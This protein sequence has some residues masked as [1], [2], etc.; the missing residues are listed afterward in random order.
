MRT[1]RARLT[2]LAILLLLAGCKETIHSDLPERE[3]NEIAAVLYAQGISPSKETQKGG[4][5]SVSVPKAEFGA[6]IA[7]LAKVGLP[8]QS[9][10]TIG[11]IFPD[12][13][14]VGTPFEERARFSFA[15]SEEL[16]RTLTEIDGVHFARVHIVIPE[17]GR[18]QDTTQPSKASLAIYHRAD[19]DPS[20]HVPQMKKLVTFAVP[21]LVYDDVS[22]SLF[23]AG[24]LTDVVISQPPRAFAASAATTATISRVVSSESDIA[25]ILFLAAAALACMVFLVRL[26]IGLKNLAG[27]VF[28]HAK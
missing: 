6:A 14:V 7:I 4:R 16:S 21:D 11:D 26:L 2:M 25:F 13:S 9:Y 28:R 19:F 3:A 1:L 18:F 17:K 12:D 27:R 24:G 20:V 23:P 5:Y 10:R 22:V 15:L 8:R